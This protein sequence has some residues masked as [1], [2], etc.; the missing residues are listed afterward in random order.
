L[1]LQAKVLAALSVTP[2]TADQIANAIGALDTAETIFLILE[3]L[4]ANGRARIA[5]FGEPGT[6]TFLK[7]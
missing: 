5:N 4:T 2:Q 3:H 6:T 1:A 7:P